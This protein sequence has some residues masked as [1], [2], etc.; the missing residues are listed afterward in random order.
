MQHATVMTA[1]PIFHAMRALK[2]NSS[3]ACSASVRFMHSAKPVAETSPTRQA[4]SKT[5]RYVTYRTK[6]KITT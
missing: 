3:A 2:K 6:K 5:A 1:V 4:A